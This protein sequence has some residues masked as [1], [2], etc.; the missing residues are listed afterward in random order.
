MPGQIS[1]RPPREA[2]HQVRLDQAGGDLQIGLDVA[3]VDPDRHAA[4]AVAQVR[5]L[6]EL[7]AVM[8]LDA[9]VGGDL[10]ADHLDQL[11]AL[12]SAGAGRWR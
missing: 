2:G 1:L 5:V 4:R 6:V 11:V 3:R 9:V 7:L 8:I 10:G 12:R